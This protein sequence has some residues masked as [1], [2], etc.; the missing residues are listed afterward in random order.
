MSTL[1][2]YQEVIRLIDVASFLWFVHSICNHL[3]FVVLF[4]IAGMESDYLN[5]IHSF[6]LKL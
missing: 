6:K 5:R 2:L 4:R 1:R 3:Y